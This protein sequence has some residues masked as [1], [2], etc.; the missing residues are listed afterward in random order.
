MESE[1]WF[2]RDCEEFV[3]TATVIPARLYGDPG[4]CHPAEYAVDPPHE[5]EFCG[6]DNLRSEYE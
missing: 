2:C 1:E 6:S 4:D 5:C 3:G